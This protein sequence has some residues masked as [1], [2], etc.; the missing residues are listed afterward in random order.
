LDLATQEDLGNEDEQPQPYGLE[1]EEE[2]DERN[3]P[4]QPMQ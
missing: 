4:Q 2:E 1:D 3:M